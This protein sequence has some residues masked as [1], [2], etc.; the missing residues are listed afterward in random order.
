MDALLLLIP[1][2]RAHAH[3]GQG[4]FDLARDWRISRKD[5]GA[6]KDWIWTGVQMLHPRI[7]VDPPAAAFSTNVFWD[8]AIAAGRAFGVVHSGEWWDV[9]TPQAIPQVEAALGYEA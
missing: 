4:D 5:P 6:P 8:R 3:A 1:K 2:A 9:G 7:L